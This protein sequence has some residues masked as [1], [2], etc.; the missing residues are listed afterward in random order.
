MQLSIIAPWMRNA[1]TAWVPPADRTGALSR[2]VRGC[3]FCATPG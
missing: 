3:L 2:H 1:G